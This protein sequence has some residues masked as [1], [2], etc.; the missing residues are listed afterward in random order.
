MIL[1]CKE[2]F[3]EH[4]PNWDLNSDI[5]FLKIILEFFFKSKF[6]MFE[7]GPYKSALPQHHLKDAF[8]S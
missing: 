4:V 6:Q 7:K 3:W 5:S 1:V 2:Q 8:K